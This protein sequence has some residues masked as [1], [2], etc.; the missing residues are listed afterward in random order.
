MLFR[1]LI[2]ARHDLSFLPKYSR[3]ALA[4][5]RRRGLAHRALAIPCGHYTMGRAPFKYI[6]GWSMIWFL[7]RNLRDESGPEGGSAGAA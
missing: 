4:H 3:Q 5:Y 1:S 2:W 6:D 7:H